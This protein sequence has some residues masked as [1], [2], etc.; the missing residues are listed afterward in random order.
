MCVSIKNIAT[1]LL[2][3]CRIGNEKKVPGLRMSRV[4][5]Q[6]QKYNKRFPKNSLIDA[7]L[8]QYPEE[9]QEKYSAYSLDHLILA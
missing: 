1:Y 7:D 9:D 8:V 6:L 5:T 4:S 2:E 3:G